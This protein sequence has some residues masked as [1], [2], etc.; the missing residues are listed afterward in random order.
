MNQSDDKIKALYEGNN[1]KIVDNANLIIQKDCFN[2]NWALYR[3]I[4]VLLW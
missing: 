4:P 3:E 2:I 1:F